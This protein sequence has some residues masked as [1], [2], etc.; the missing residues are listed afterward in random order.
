ML[1]LFVFVKSKRLRIALDSL[2]GRIIVKNHLLRQ[3][4]KNIYALLNQN[5]GFGVYEIFI[6]KDLDF[7]G[8][9]LKDSGLAE[10]FIRVLN[11]DKGNRFIPFPKADYVVEKGDKLLVYGKTENVLEIF[12]LTK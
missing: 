3:S 6:E 7:A 11:V 8:K 12:N 1:L 5:N 10:N 4:K 2:I 9:P